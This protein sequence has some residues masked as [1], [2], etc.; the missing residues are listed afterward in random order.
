MR[1]TIATIAALTALGTA[2]ADTR[3]PKVQSVP[4]RVYDP[5]TR[6]V[7]IQVDVSPDTYAVRTGG[8]G[9]AR[10]FP[11]VD[12]C[13]MVDNFYGRFWRCRLPIYYS[14][15]LYSLE[16]G[17]MGLSACATGGDYGCSEIALEAT[18]ACTTDPPGTGC[19]CQFFQRVY[20][21][22]VCTPP[23]P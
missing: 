16:R 15:E 22:G 17:P 7:S 3:A 21:D 9:G 6:L 1:R 4:L 2:W 5:T 12:F 23:T 19:P 18:V 10:Y 11:V 8:I 14:G 13:R 20:E